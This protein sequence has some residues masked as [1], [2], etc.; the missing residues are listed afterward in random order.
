VIKQKISDYDAKK[1]NPICLYHL[2]DDNIKEQLEYYGFNVLNDFIIDETNQFEMSPNFF[3]VIFFVDPTKK[4]DPQKNTDFCMVVGERLEKGANY[5]YLGEGSFPTEN[6]TCNF[7]QTPST[8]YQ[9][10]L[11]LFRYIEFK[12][13]V[14]NL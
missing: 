4:P 14:K 10:L 12:K 8:V 2:K 1:N 3:S 5:F 6:C 13:S 9:N 11:D 7:A